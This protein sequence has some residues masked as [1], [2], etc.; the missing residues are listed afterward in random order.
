MWRCLVTRQQTLFLLC[1]FF[2][3]SCLLPKLSVCVQCY[4]E[5]AHLLLLFRL[6]THQV[7]ITWNASKSLPVKLATVL[8]LPKWG[9][10]NLFMPV[11]LRRQQFRSYL[12]QLRQ[13]LHK[14]VMLESCFV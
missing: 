4:S 3:L 6:N 8:S 7:Q 11:R 5:T 2:L 10:R 9:K 14:Q 13:L 1:T 12:Y